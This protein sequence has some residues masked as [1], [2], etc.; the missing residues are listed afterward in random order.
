MQGSR[1]GTRS[2]VRSG[3]YTGL[4]T[5]TVSAAAALAG[6]L[7]ARKFGHGAKTD[8]FFAAY[9]VYIVLLLVASA[10]RVVVLPELARAR[11]TGAL[12]RETGTWALAL[13]VP[14]VP[15]VVVAVA[16]PDAI[17]GV[18]TGNGAGKASAAELLP[19]L[20]PAAAAQVLA[21]LAASALGALDDY[22]TAAAG[23]ATG[24]VVGLI[25]IAALVDHGVIAFGYGLS[26][27]AAIALGVPLAVVVRRA[28][29]A[30]PG[31]AVG[32]RLWTLVEGVALPFAL[33]GLYLIAYRFASGL[34]SGRPTTFSYA[35]LIASF[36]VAITATSIALVSSVPLTR[37]ELTPARTTRHVVSASWICLPVVALLAG[38]F[39]L[40]GEQIARL[41]LGPDYGGSTGSELG[42]LV[43]YLSPWSVASV[44][45]SV[46][47]PL[48]FVRGRAR[49]LPLLAVGAL[50][51]QVLVEWACSAAFGLGGVAAG[52]AVTTAL[53]LAVLLHS[54]G[55]LAATARGVVVAAVACGL[56]AV[57]AFALA[58]LL[59]GPA[60]A[61]VVGALLYAVALAV[62]RPAPLLAAWLYLRHL[63]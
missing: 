5:A 59:L 18:I 16:A 51:V 23:F 6:A 43:G 56:P 61:A 28:A 38:I 7:L 31:L 14:L 55:A 34:G 49:W 3:L 50:G 52:M 63:G 22:G 32:R 29:L 57:A 35:Y 48:L 45:L 24:A 1:A 42:R 47:F 40:A 17:A 41:V 30:L 62:W 60:A 19:W 44:A 53:V 13:A 11:A 10:L 46:T 2:A 27:N 33:Q 8:G 36:L 15:A 21:G 12:G 25:V 54:L 58:A 39:A 4:S 20:V 26:V 37:T 9:A